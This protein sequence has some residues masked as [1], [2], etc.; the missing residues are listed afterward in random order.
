M[1]K[2]TEEQQKLLIQADV[3]HDLGANSVIAANQLIERFE[4]LTDK[5]K[6]Y[7]KML[8]SKLATAND[9][10]AK[11]I[12]A[13]LTQG[14]YLLDEET[15]NVA[16]EQFPRVVKTLESP[17]FR[18]YTGAVVIVPTSSSSSAKTTDAPVPKTSGVPAS[19][20]T[21]GGPLLKGSGV[22]SGKP[23]TVDPRLVTNKA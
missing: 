15:R 5:G 13:E 19:K 4:K 21:S 11:L 2:L 20:P 8:A 6:D 17:G 23:T 7:A 22:S 10:N 1:A 14:F 12:G 3:N 18:A 9:G 16:R